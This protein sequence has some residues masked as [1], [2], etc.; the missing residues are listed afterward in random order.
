M[1]RYVTALCGI[2]LLMAMAGSFAEDATNASMPSLIKNGGFEKGGMYPE[3]WIVPED[4]SVRFISADPFH[5]RILELSNL[6][7]PT[8]NV[9]TYKSPIVRIDESLRY[10]FEA[11]I[12]TL[13]AD[14]ALTFM[15]YGRVRG[16]MQPV[17]RAMARYRA[18]NGDWRLVRRT[19][20]PHCRTYKAEFLQ[21]IFSASGPPGSVYIDNVSLTPIAKPAGRRVE[22]ANESPDTAS[23]PPIA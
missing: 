2:I 23:N 16:K 11:D 10:R 12:K 21:V 20:R 1:R 8:S 9:V 13:R 5:G 4:E 14:F 6:A 3:G 17:Y 7:S 18:D 22:K 15:G 19:F